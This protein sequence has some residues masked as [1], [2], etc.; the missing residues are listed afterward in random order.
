MKLRVWHEGSY[1]TEQV[2]IF[3]ISASTYVKFDDESR[4]EDAGALNKVT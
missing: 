3:K 4:Y 1:N 2:G